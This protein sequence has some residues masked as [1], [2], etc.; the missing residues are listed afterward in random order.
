MPHPSPPLPSIPSWGLCCFLQE[1]RTAVQHYMKGLG[2]RKH[3]F[4]LLIYSWQK[5]QKDRRFKGKCL[6]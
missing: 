1:A 4:Y 5:R 2:E 3:L 6:N